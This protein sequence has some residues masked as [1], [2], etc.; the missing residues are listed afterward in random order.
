MK[1]WYIANLIWLVWTSICLLFFIQINS[2]IKKLTNPNC[3]PNPK[4]YTVVI[5]GCMVVGYGCRIRLSYTVKYEIR[6][7]VVLY[8][9]IRLSYTVKY[10][11]VVYREIRLWYTVKYGCRIPWNTVIY[12]C[13]IRL[14]DPVVG[15]ADPV[16][17]SRYGIRLTVYVYG[18]SDPVVLYRESD[19]RIRLSVHGMGSV[20]RIRGSGSYTVNRIQLSY[21]YTDPVVAY[22]YTAN[23]IRLSTLTLTLNCIR[24]Y[25]VV[26][27][28]CIRYTVSTYGQH[29]R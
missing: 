8:R 5:Y 9:E 6:N 27:Y 4:L 12:G 26:I 19:P 28:G 14:L 10:T 11:V 20:N 23:R 3:N 25:T 16:V 2:N 13:W 18:E 7:T 17:S 24:S 15:S 22:A 1:T 29:I 21:T